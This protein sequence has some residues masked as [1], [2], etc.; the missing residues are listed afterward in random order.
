[1]LVISQMQI[2]SMRYYFKSIMLAK[3]KKKNYV[4]KYLALVS[5][6]SNWIKMFSLKLQRILRHHVY[7]Y[8]LGK[9]VPSLY[10]KYQKYLISLRWLYLIS[11]QFHFFDTRFKNSMCASKDMTREVLS[12]NSNS[13]STLNIFKVY[14]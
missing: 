9:F 2:N 7:S 11:L 4:W 10:K 12:S 5:I 3:K 14:Q 13:N 1:M 6:W 8:R